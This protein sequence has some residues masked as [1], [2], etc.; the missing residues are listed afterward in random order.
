[1]QV[2][3]LKPIFV[4]VF[5]LH[6]QFFNICAMVYDCAKRNRYLLIL[7]GRWRLIMKTVLFTLGAAMCLAGCASTPT[8]YGPAGNGSLGFNDYQIQK[9]RFHVSFTGKNPEEAQRYVLRRAAELTLNHQFDH[10]KVVRSDTYGGGY[11]SPVSSSIGVGVGSGGGYH[12]RTRTNVGIGI[13]V[14]DVAQA[15]SGD[16]VTASMEIIAQTGGS[17]DPDVYDAKSIVN[18]IQPAVFTP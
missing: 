18:S 1:V 14:H 8:S 12:G 11:R 5:R 6:K 2:I 9:D 3:S 17:S 7:T 10:F 13:G 4:A 16:R 15:M